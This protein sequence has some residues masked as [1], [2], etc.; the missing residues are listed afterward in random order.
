MVAE[1]NGGTLLVWKPIIG[2]NSETA[3]IHIIGLFG[4]EKWEFYKNFYPKYLYTIL[5]SPLYPHA[6]ST[7]ASVIPL[8]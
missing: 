4:F 8:F 7:L 6:Q 2:H 5:F 3:S 1:F